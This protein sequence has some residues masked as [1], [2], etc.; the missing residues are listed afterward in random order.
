VVCG[1]GIIVTIP[2]GLIA[3]AAM[4]EDFFPRK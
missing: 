1:I 2:I 4:L 3:V